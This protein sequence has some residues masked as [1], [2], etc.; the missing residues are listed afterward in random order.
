MT[1]RKSNG[2]IGQKGMVASPRFKARSPSLE[3]VIFEGQLD[4][5]VQRFREVN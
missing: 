3:D 2:R 5:F 1:A 4:A